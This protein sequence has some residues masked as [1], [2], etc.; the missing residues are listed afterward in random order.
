MTFSNNSAL[1]GDASFFS[2]TAEAG[3]GAAAVVGAVDAAVVAAVTPSFGGVF[4]YN[5]CA[6]GGGV[7]ENTGFSSLGGLLDFDLDFD[8]EYFFF[9][10]A[11]GL[12]DGLFFA[13]FG[14]LWMILS[15]LTDGLLPP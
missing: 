10:P 9:L 5:G 7:L 1:V 12:A 3:A 14:G 4:A 6:L 2:A 13:S 8:L 11:G 15:G